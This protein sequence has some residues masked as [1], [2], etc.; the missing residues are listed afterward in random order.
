MPLWGKTDQSV[1]ANSTTTKETSTGAPIGTQGLVKK[2]RNIPGTAANAHFGNTS[3]GSRASIDSTM[4]G[5]V[6]PGAFISGASIGVFGVSA[7][8]MANNTVNK[9]KEAPAHAGWV[10]RTAGTGG[11]TQVAYTGTATG[12]SNTDVLTVS[13][14]QAGGNATFSVSTNATGG[15]LSFAQINPGK[16]FF[17]VNATANVVIANST[18]GASGGS[19]ATFTA[20]AGGRA[21][22]V[23]TETLVAMGSISS[24]GS[25][26]T[27]Y[28]GS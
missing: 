6:T 20:V 7:T 22:R 13:S 23:F 10:V 15:A 16:G 25:D 1:S 14:P 8:E 12:Y 21:G 28:P 2:G 3:S 27:Q 9:S 18:G 26:N 17:V 11:I 5:N 19:G 4:Y 24:D